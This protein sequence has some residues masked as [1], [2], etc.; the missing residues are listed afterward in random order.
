MKDI[1]GWWEWGQGVGPLAGK[2]II[3][4]IVWLVTWAVLNRLWRDKEVDLKAF[5]YR[6]LAFGIVGVIGTFPPFFELFE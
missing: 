5:F 4:V 1:L 2:T 6:G 3:A